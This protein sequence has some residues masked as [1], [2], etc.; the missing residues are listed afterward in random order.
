MGIQ[1]D[2]FIVSSHN[3]VTSARQLAGLLDVPWTGTD[4]FL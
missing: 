3:R 1:L 4:G 2:H